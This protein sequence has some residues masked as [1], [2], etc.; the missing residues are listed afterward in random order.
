MRTLWNSVWHDRR[1]AAMAE[2]AAAMPVLVILLLGGV[3][4]SRFAMLNQKIDRLATTMGDLV[5]QA[6]TLTESD[7]DK[8]FL[9]AEHV[10]WPF[11]VKTK[12][13]I[14][15]S[16]ISIPPDQT[17]AR[18]TWQKFS[19]GGISAAVTSKIGSI[20]ATPALPSGMVVTGANTLIVSEVYFDFEPMFVGQLMSAHRIYHRAFFRPRVGSLTTLN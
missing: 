20:G 8:V 6:D 10:A 3:E 2:L 15:I 4:I 5:A 14:I 17:A 18:L 11:P 16:S 1:G 7:V 12:A 13:A 9:A 19:S